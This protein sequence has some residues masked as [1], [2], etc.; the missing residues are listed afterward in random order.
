MQCTIALYACFRPRIVAQKE[1]SLL[2][3][4][5]ILLVFPLLLSMTLF[6]ER[7]YIL[8][9]VLLA[10]A[11]ASRASFSDT[12]SSPLPSQAEQPRAPSPSHTI[13]IASDRSSSSSSS[14]SPSRIHIVQLPALTI[15][16]AHMMLMTILAILAVDF[17]AFPRSLAKCETFG[18]SLVC[19][20]SNNPDCRC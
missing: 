10:L 11:G 8:C 19:L 17:P 20:H 9:S 5:W 4:E 15:Y 6:A 1:L 13:E 12:P 16:R 14:S 3:V 7:P 18:V 2:L